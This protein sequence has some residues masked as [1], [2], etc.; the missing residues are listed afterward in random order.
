MEAGKINNIM[1]LNY[2]N[3]KNLKEQKKETVKQSTTLQS[4]WTDDPKSLEL[5]SLFTQKF[6]PTIIGNTDQFKVKDY[7]Q[8]LEKIPDTQLSQ[9]GE[10][11]KNLGYSQPN[12]SIKKFQEDL[13]NSSEFSTF[14][15]ASGEQKQFNDGIFGIATAKAILLWM[16]QKYKKINP[17][18]LFSDLNKKYQSMQV[19]SGEKMMAPKVETPTN[20]QLA[21]DT[22]RVSK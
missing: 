17:D 8:A 12:P 13:M 5:I 18:I 11:F 15:T 10:F 6:I 22:Q 20:V 7:L 4:T 9:V 21:V 2:K 16:I 14:T 1:I 3:W 19:A